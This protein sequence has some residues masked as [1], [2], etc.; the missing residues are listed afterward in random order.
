MNSAA[1]AMATAEPEVRTVRAE[2]LSESQLR[3]LLD[4][5]PDFAGLDPLPMLRA[6]AHNK[7]R[8]GRIP[9]D[10]VPKEIA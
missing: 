4:W 9:A 6:A 1:I 3:R 7:F 8:G 10:L 2:T 5:D